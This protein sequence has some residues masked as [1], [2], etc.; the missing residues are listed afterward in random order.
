MAVDFLSPQ[1]YGSAALLAVVALVWLLVGAPT[2]E[3]VAG[4][5]FVLVGS[6]PQTVGGR[7]ASIFHERC[8]EARRPPGHPPRHLHEHQ[9]SDRRDRVL[10]RRMGHGCH[11]FVWIKT[12]DEAL[13][14]ARRRQTTSD[15]GR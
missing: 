6:P 11:P 15:A 8:R 5:G 2:K 1:S 12:P 7:L 3:A 10:H 14:H 9:G 13:S 4:A